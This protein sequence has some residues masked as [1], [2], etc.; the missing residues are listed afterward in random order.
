MAAGAPPVPLPPTP[1]PPAMPPPAVDAPPTPP[2]PTTL[3]LRHLACGFLAG[4]A[5]VAVGYPLDTIKVRLQADKNGLAFGGSIL[6]A[7]RAVVAAGGARGLYRGMTSPLVGGAAETAVNYAVYGTALERITAALAAAEDVARG[8]RPP[9]AGAAVAAGEDEPHHEQQQQQPPSLAAVAAAAAVAGVAL[10]VVL[11]P[12]ELVKC[13]LQM[14]QYPTPLAC[15]RDVVARHGWKG[16]GRGFGATVARE[17]PGNAVFFVAYEWA[18]RGWWGTGSGG[19]G[20]GGGSSSGD[21]KQQQKQ[22]QQQPG[23]R[24]SEGG[25][26][27]GDNSGGRAAEEDDDGAWRE[28]LANVGRAT[29]CGAFAGTAMW[30][31]VLP[32]DVAKTR[33]QAA[34]P[35]SAWDRPLRW[36]LRALWREGGFRAL[37]AGAR[38]TV[39]RAVPA[40]AAQWAVWEAAMRWLE[41]GGGGGET[42]GGRRSSRRM[43]AP[44]EA[45]PPSAPH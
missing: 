44:P 9:P 15:V 36:H 38:P 12:T 27:G 24:R 13:R 6:R 30:L 26:N 37:W 4:T 11:A 45:P 33:I 18:R 19:G 5:N 20:D 1:P 21:G 43:A 8:G 31:S 39:V 7:G 25:E 14:S 32:L 2:S 10:S 23:R 40:N 42:E 29:V 3:A 28:A 34:H 35:G 17:A 22:H 16:M 41:D